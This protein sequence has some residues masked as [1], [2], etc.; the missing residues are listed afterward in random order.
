MARLA[1]PSAPMPR[2]TPL[3]EHVL[4]P[5]LCE[6]CRRHDG[7]P[8]GQ[9][10]HDRAPGADP[11]LETSCRQ[12]SGDGGNG[13]HQDVDGHLLVAQPEELLGDRAGKPDHDLH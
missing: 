3:P 5:R 9:S 6:R 13:E 4:A 10:D 11:I 8:Q 1:V 2:P 7:K 12:R